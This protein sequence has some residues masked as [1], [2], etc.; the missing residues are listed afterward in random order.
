MPVEPGMAPVVTT[1]HS[2]AVLGILL[3][4]TLFVTTLSATTASAQPAHFGRASATPSEPTTRTTDATQ[5]F[6]TADP[7]PPTF[8][9][10]EVLIPVGQ[11]IQAAVDAHPAGTAFRIAAGVHRLQSV[12][13][14]DGNT[15]TGEPGAVLNGARVLDPA[16]FRRV[17]GRWVLDGQDLSGFVHGEVEPGAERHAHPFDL[18]LGA[19][20]ADHVASRAAV[21]APGRW[22]L[23]YDRDEI[24]LFDDPSTVGGV[25]LSVVESAFRSDADDVT[26]QHLTVTRYA[27]PAQH[28][29]IHAAEG[30]RWE[31]GYVTV[32]QAH[33]SGIRIGPGMH[34]HHSR[35]SDAGQL[36]VGGTDEHDGVKLPVLVEFNEIFNNRT[37]RYYWGWEGGATK[38][39]LT[40]DLVFQNN[41]VH[42]NRGPGVWFDV[43]NADAVIRANVVEGNDQ[44]GIFYEISFG[45]EIY[46]NVVRDNGRQAVGDEGAGIHVS[47]SRDVEIHHNAIYG[48]RSAILGTQ[49]DRGS[50]HLGVRETVGL[51]AHHN[52]IVPGEVAQGIRVDY[53]DPTH[54][55]QRAGNRM[56]AN[57]YRMAPTAGAF[58]AGEQLDLAGWQARGYE[59]D[60]VLAAAGSTPQLRT[61]SLAFTAA[62]VGPA[63]NL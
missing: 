31:V 37:L 61:P 63:L 12:Q 14:R 13:P 44:A 9:G 28:G 35:I 10:T 62:P 58:W 48:N 53:G 16:A 51:Y 56:E 45:A 60:A 36:G 25:E 5:S 18:F 59:R 32:T 24:V 22:F 46:D 43:D 41:W 49:G 11:S 55:Y 39:A 15:F 23:D 4:A 29:A 27:S 8:S 42:D 19:A 26:I 50:S 30:L 21:S 52:D 47:N 1:S 6:P 7:V 34:L 38:F 57:T 54:F 17:D 2:S 20:R 33:G 3:A 40:T